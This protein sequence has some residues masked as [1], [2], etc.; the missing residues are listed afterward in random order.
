MPGDASAGALEGHSRLI[1]RVHRTAGAARWG[2][3]IERFTEAVA[4]SCERRFRPEPLD[5]VAPREIRRYIRSLHAA[6]LALACACADGSEAAWVECL[7]K[8]RSDLYAAARAIAGRDSARELADSLYAD[9]YGLTERD[10]K[11]R[12]LFDYFHG[13][14]KLSTWL[15]SVLA[16]RYVDR[17]RASRRLRSLDDEDQAPAAAS[18]L[19]AAN[20]PPEPDRSRL[21]RLFRDAVAQAVAS[22]PPGDRLRLSYYYVHS[23]KL[24][25]IGRLMGEHESSASRK[26]ER[27]RRALRADVEHRLSWHG[28]KP[29]DVQQ[30]Y[31][32]GTEEGTWDLAGVWGKGET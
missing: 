22:L 7:S 13:R 28:L 31:E 9:L 23:L 21:G 12:P 19:T 14:S 4:R 1:A 15:R 5:S 2:L 20:P 32:R 10:G 6:D 8:Y 29:D 26:L 30:C 27:A 3:S 24:A 16:Q 11:R 25:E 17:V 18:R